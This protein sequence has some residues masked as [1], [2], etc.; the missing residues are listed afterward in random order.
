MLDKIRK[1]LGESTYRAWIRQVEFSHITTSPTHSDW[2]K[3]GES[4]EPVPQPTV[5]VIHLHLPNKFMR[6]Y[7][8]EH[9]SSH[10]T[11]AWQEVLVCKCR[12]EFNLKTKPRPL[13][14]SA[15]MPELE[16]SAIGRSPEAGAVLVAD[17]LA[18]LPF[19]ANGAEVSEYASTQLDSRNTFENFVV[20]KPNELAFAAARRVA[21]FKGDFN[22][23]FLYGGVGLGK[24]HLMH[25]I[26]WEIRS[27]FP[28]RKVIYMS[29]EKFMNHFIN[30]IRFKNMASFK[31]EF[32]TVDVL[33]ID[34]VQFICG[35]DNTQEE[36]FHTFNALVDQ[37]HRIVI[38]A[39]KS[40]SDLELDDRLRSRLGWGLVADIHPST[41]ELR[42]GILKA[43][44]EF[45]KI[46]IHDSVLSFL[47]HKI[48][49]NIRELE[50]AFNRIIA[51]I[52]LLG[53]QV[54]VE[55]VQD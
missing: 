36:F 39:D 5:R 7:V 55:M 11:R 21:E 30:A 32:R 43:K 14:A 28:E 1:N 41:Y 53:V 9:F 33:M 49:S 2:R 47:A 42:L 34:D 46:E 19:V 23:L 48:S 45:E 37:Q 31:K 12:V 17:S 25:A 52:N 3:V 35:K 15:Q 6:D 54:T 29:A 8:S 4:H 50:G 16:P 51:N 22:P 27:N 24:T 38:S 18:T 44:A 20:G 13:Q 26:A 40:P 10:L